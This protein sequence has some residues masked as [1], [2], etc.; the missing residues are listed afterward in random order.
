MY[1][2]FI[3]IFVFG[4]VI[5]SFLNCLIW[6]L[7]SEETV[8][9]RSYC[10][11]CRKQINWYDNIPVFSFLLLKGKCRSCHKKISWQYPLVELSTGLLFVLAFYINTISIF[12]SL[13]LLFDLFLICI[14]IIIFIF[15][16]RFMLVPIKTIWISAL[17]LLVLNLFLGFSLWQMFLTTLAGVTFFSLQYFATKGKGLGEGDIWIGGLLGIA[18]PSWSHFILALFLTYLIGGFIATILLIFN[19]KKLGSKLPLGIFLSSGALIS[20]FFA[21]NIMNWFFHLS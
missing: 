21:E 9:G 20:L 15:D 19:L 17:V 4:L 13:K 3:L 18:F 8:L 16:L 7:Y 11:K 5:G 14:L 2:F 12:S 1:L 6:R 10:P